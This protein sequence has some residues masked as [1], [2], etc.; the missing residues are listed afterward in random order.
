MA[1]ISEAMAMASI[2]VGLVSIPAASQSLNGPTNFSDS[3]TNISAAGD[4]PRSESTELSQDRF[5]RTV[6]NA[7]HGFREEV[8]SGSTNVSLENPNSRLS[9]Q[10]K[11]S[12]TVYV[13]ISPEGELR[14]EKSANGIRETVTT[15]AGTLLRQREQGNIREEFTGSDREKVEDAARELR[16]LMEQKKTRIDSL[17]QDSR[18]Q[19]RPDIELE[20]KPDEGE[21]VKLTNAGPKPVNMEDWRIEDEGG[22]A[23]SFPEVELSPGA[24]VT[25]YTGDG[26]DSDSELYW[27]TSSV[28]NNDGDT[29]TLYNSR[30]EE[31]SSE[32]Y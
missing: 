8:S 31:V 16:Q 20:V 3:L 24:T 10:K 18:E 14:I 1:T 6:G 2:I 15:P 21:Y 32:S 9:I 25:L 4:V 23:Y 22:N 28:W 12:G 11:P 13:L 17:N 7:F 29:A 5:V 26:E 30:G 27:G 19:F